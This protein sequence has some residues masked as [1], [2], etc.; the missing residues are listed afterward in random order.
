MTAEEI[1]LTK[2]LAYMLMVSVIIIT[3]IIKVQ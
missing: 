1:E 3:S 2:E